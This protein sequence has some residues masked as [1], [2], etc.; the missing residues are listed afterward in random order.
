MPSNTPGLVS[1]RRVV[2]VLAIVF[3]GSLIVFGASWIL[4]P[5]ALTRSDPYPAFMAD[6]KRRDS[7]LYEDAIRRFSDFV[8]ETFPIGADMSDAVAQITKGG[9]QVTS[10]TSTSVKLVWNRRN[11]PCSEEYSIVVGGDA[12]GK[13]AEIA[14]RLHPICL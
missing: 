14:G 9:F 12:A 7:P 13:I 10:S 6:L 11:G 1:M 4:I 2:I 3:A 5:Y 8:A